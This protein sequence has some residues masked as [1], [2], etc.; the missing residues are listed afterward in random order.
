VSIYDDVKK[1]IQDQLAPDLQEIKG[2]IKAL[3]VRMDALEQK[4]D[5]RIEGLNQRFDQLIDKLEF[6]K[7]LENLERAAAAKPQ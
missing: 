2:E 3:N 5:Y 4:L 1:A 7:R 6:D